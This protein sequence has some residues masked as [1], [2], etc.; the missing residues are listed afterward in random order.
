MPYQIRELKG[1]RGKAILFGTEKLVW[2][3]NWRK[4]EKQCTMRIIVSNNGHQ[5]MIFPS[6]I[7]GNPIQFI[8]LYCSQEKNLEG[9]V[10]NFMNYLSE[11]D[12]KLE[13]EKEESK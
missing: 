4:C 1:W 2:F 6:D 9:A 7:D 3:Y 11:I 5:T 10:D 13:M 12:R 8:E